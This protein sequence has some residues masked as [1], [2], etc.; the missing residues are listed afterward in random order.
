MKIRDDK[1]ISIE[2]LLNLYNSVGWKNYTDEPS[3]LFEAVRN[4]TFVFTC[5]DGDQLIGLVRGMSDAVSIFYL[6]DILV[7]PDYQGNGIGSKLLKHCL[8]KYQSVRQTVLI[9]DDDERLF[10]FYESLGFKN[11]KKLKKHDINAFLKFSYVDLE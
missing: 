5:W 11:L 4:S 6:Q 10:G 1:E 3:K 2:H 8:N 7:N 9:T